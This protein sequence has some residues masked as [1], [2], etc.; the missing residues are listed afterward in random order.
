MLMP[1]PGFH[2]GPPLSEGQRADVVLGCRIAK[3]IARLEIG[4]SVVLR[5]GTVL[6]VEAFEGT[7]RCLARG[8][9]LAGPEGGAVAVKLARPDHDLRFDLPCIGLRTL[10]VCAGAKI[11]VLAFEADTT[12]LLEQEE[13]TR[14]AHQ[15]RLALTSFVA[16]AV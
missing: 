7:D 2:L 5:N 4:Q 11:A 12:L 14:F 6:A 8:G 9:E 1:G 10:E 13:V 3:E 16:A 15:H